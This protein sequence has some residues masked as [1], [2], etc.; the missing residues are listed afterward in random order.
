MQKVRIHYDLIILRYCPYI[1][2]FLPNQRMGAMSLSI[3]LTDV[4]DRKDAK[5]FIFFLFPTT[6]IH[7][8]FKD[9]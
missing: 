3:F 7:V 9:L 5:E 4:L 2:I 8:Y 6:I 1:P